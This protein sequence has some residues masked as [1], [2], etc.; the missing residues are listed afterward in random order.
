M[1]TAQQ[2]IEKLNLQSL[3]GEGG[4]FVETYRS[5]QVIPAVLPAGYTGDRH[6]STAIYYLLT[7]GT[8]SALHQL[9]GDEVYHFYAG[10]PV[11][12]LQLKPD[13]T[14]EVI[15]IGPD[16]LGGMRPQVVV[17]GGAWQGS[18]LSPGGKF[19]LLGATMS[20]GFEF[21]DY[22]GARRQE[23]TSQYPQFA[24]LIAALTGVS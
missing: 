2:V 12:M 1:L 9:P 7:P 16:I 22:R 18:R 11:E 15:L 20:P 5:P 17:H 10:D 23:L 13:G 4:F 6:L 8:C 21:A 3:P 19:A 14:G 24:A